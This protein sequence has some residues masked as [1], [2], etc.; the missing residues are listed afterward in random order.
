MTPPAPPVLLVEPNRTGNVGAVARIMA[1][2]GLSDL[3]LVG[4]PELPGDRDDMA[5]RAEGRGLLER[6]RAAPRPATLREALT[7]VQVAIAV[8]RRRGKHRPTDLAPADLVPLV[9]GLPRGTSVAL[10]FGREADGLTVDEIDLCGRRLAIPT[11]PEAP[12]LNLA[13]AVGVVAWSWFA[14]LRQVG[15]RAAGGGSVADRTPSSPA[16]QVARSGSR[17]PS[18]LEFKELSD[19]LATLDQ[20]EAFLEQLHPGLERLGFFEG[21]RGP[22]AF[23]SLRRIFMRSGLTER[24]VRLLRGLARKL[25]GEEPEDG[26]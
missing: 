16:G 22:D 1:N 11:V 19:R 20:I 21:N 7:G 13:Q 4:S 17:H 8:T 3:R 24:E 12:S 23:R 18:A 26:R 14:G 5:A 25:S 2:F 9:E 15:V 6:L 10:V